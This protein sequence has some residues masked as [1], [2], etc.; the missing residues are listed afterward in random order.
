MLPK[1]SMAASCLT[2]TFFSRHAH[3]AAR[4]RHRDDHGQ[5]LGREPH[6]ERHR[7]EERLEQV[8]P[9]QGVDQE[10]EQHQEDHDLED[11]ERRTGACRA[12]TRSRAARP[13]RPAATRPNSV[14]GAGR[15]HDRRR[16][17][18][19]PPRCPGTRRSPRSPRPPA[20][21]RRPGRLLLAGQRLA[22]ERG[23]VDE[24]V[25]A[26]RAARPSAG[27][28]SPA[29]QVDHVARP[30]PRAPASR[31][32]P[33]RGPRSRSGPTCRRRRSA[34]CWERYAW[35]KLSA[36]LSD[37]H[38]RDDHRADH[39]A[40]RGRDHAR[41]EQDQH[42]RIGEVAPMHGAPRSAGAGASSFG[43]SARG[44]AAASGDRPPSEVSSSVQISARPRVQKGSARPA[45]GGLAA[46]LDALTRGR[47]PR[48]RPCGRAAG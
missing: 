12:R 8:A 37:E 15:H 13:T 39:L 24:Q 3:R 45:G 25:P 6:R 27:T 16:R 35:V 7:E 11:Q 14:A 34:A 41:H 38:E 5:Q 17:A 28:R 1:F 32:R 22:G 9:Q 2:M 43:P 10:D 36:T 30:P 46:R 33:R 20:P 4:Q 40:E 21:A 42:E 44:A 29:L 19:S 48:P 23:L 31:A 47:R 26:S 18:R